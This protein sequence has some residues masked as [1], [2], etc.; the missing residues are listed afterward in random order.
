MERSNT[1]CGPGRCRVNALTLNSLKQLFGRERFTPSVHHL[2]DCGTHLI[3]DDA[4]L[5]A[6]FSREA[7]DPPQDLGD[8]A[9]LPE[10]GRT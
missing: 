6:I 1:R 7:A 9:A 4:N 3:G 10:Q 8:R 2:I 5:W